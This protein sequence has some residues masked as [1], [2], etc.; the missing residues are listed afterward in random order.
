MR[1]SFA[2]VEHAQGRVNDDYNSWPRV[3]Y[4][5]VG[6]DT[7][8]MPNTGVNFNRVRKSL[9]AG[10]N[11]EL[12]M[13]GG[14]TVIVERL[15]GGLLDI[16]DPETGTSGSF[17]PA[18]VHAKRYKSLTLNEAKKARN[19]ADDALKRVKTPSRLEAETTGE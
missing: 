6:A 4:L 13:K 19:V 8:S 5:K 2:I 1:N 18:D 16:Y 17:R 11:V 10:R 14:Y 3:N 9:D 12:T 15:R 7:I